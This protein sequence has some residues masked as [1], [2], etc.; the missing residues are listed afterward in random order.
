MIITK[1]D[2]F[3]KCES[4][5][6]ISMNM[7]IEECGTFAMHLKRYRDRSN[8]VDF[9]LH[10]VNKQQITP[11]NVETSSSQVDAFVCK[12]HVHW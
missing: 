9:L 6:C 8:V 1:G 3:W 11:N 7:G 5:L 4:P 2:Y 10:L 12:I